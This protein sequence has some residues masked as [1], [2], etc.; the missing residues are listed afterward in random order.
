ML[1]FLKKKKKEDEESEP[2][3]EEGEEGEA[4]TDESKEKP[5]DSDK[6]KSSMGTA[7]ILSE[8]E[9]I[10][11]S[12]EAFQEVRKS[13]T[14][15][16][17]RVSEEI[18]ELRSMIL[19]RDKLVHEIEL[20]S[21]K[22]SNLVESVQPEKLMSEVRRGDAK[23]EAL[24]ANIE[25]NETIS[26]RIMEE[27]K[28]IKKKIEFFGGIDEIISLSEEIK[29]ELVEIKKVEGFIKINSDK[30]QT[31][32]AEMRARFQEM[33][34]FRDDFE[35]IKASME[36]NTKDVDFLKNKVLGLAEKDDLDKLMN[37]VQRYIEVL[38]DLE[39]KSS[40]TKDIDQLKEL[41]DNI[42]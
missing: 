22:A 38:K 26:E 28:D 34:I 13:F 14:E 5:K 18:G 32:Y 19:D 4:E 16:F 41:L 37:K 25:G 20:H 39:K 15:R 40:L 21:V 30:V 24:R 8:I 9:K 10:K 17:D 35:E 6:E 42:K 31:I 1:D 33:D 36:Q 2:E 3:P 23:I 27:I 29:K 12:L 7:R 11:A